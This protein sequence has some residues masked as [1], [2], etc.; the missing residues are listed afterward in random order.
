MLSS[1][2]FGRFSSNY[3]SKKFPYRTQ[4]FALK[5]SFCEVTKGKGPIQITIREALN[6]ALDEEIARDPAVFLMGEE[7]AKYN[8][9]YKVSK[10]LHD[11]WGDKRLIDTPITEAGFAGIG[12]GAA[13]AGCRPVI[14]FMTWNFAMQAIDQIVNSAAKL[15]YMSGGKV[16]M[17]ITFRGPNGPPTSVGAQHSQCFAAWYGSVPGLKVVAISNADNAKGLLKA[18]IR[19]DNPVVVLE[20]ELLY[21]ET[22]TLSAEAQDPNFLIPIGRANVEV[23]G[24]D[25]TI[26]TFSR[27]VGQCLKAATKLKEE[28]ISAEVIDLRSIRPLD[29]ATIITSVAKTG[30]C[31]TVEEGWPHFGVGSEISAQLVEHAFDYLDAPIRRV[32]GAD[33][34]MPYSKAIEDLAMVQIENIV[35]QA[36]LTVLGRK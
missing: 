35:N 32:T 19:D 16:K 12:V 28:G 2:K 13:A 22:M 25:I 21:N 6:H 10:G 26:V 23:Q 29:I 36:K 17:P 4:N 30:K 3:T 9:A 7:V 24:N 31:I 27:M 33:V 18:A 11:K 20:S 14:E 34:P 8:G 1:K 15:L 5:K